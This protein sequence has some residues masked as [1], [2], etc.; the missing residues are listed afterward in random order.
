[1]RPTFRVASDLKLLQRDLLLQ[2]APHH[3]DHRVELRPRVLA[4]RHHSDQRQRGQLVL[5]DDWPVWHKM[6]DIYHFEKCLPCRCLLCFFQHNIASMSRQ[7]I[8]HFEIVHQYI[9]YYIYI[10]YIY[11]VVLFLLTPSSMLS[12]WMRES[13][14]YPS[15][16][17]FNSPSKIEFKV[18]SLEKVGL[19]LSWFGV[20]VLNRQFITSPRDFI[21]LWLSSAHLQIAVYSKHTSSDWKWIQWIYKN[22]IGVPKSKSYFSF[23]GSSTLSSCHSAFLELWL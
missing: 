4:V 2:E 21:L 1:M 9:A 19:T 22:V 23:L 16:R 11:I 10:Y 6:K 17:S 13:R 14:F 15:R 8:F 7:L 20:H 12:N 5:C 18:H 3:A